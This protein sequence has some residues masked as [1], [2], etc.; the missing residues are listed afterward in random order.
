MNPRN[1]TF[2]LTLALGLLLDQATKL[3]VAANLELSESEIPVVPGWLSIVHAQNTGA[4][5]ST[6]EGALPLFLV[7]TV[8]AVVV[9]LDLVRRQPADL[10]II[11]LSLGMILAGAVG[12]GLDRA[13]MGHVTDFVKVYAG[14]EPLRSWFVESRFGTNVWPIFNVADSLLLVGVAVF[15]LYWLT[16]RDSE[17][18]PD[19]EAPETASP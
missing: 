17:V 11:P 8:I 15:G 13:R 10:R 18:M 16:L 19:D 9:I 4:A 6:M 5:F 12:N 2:T 7:F 1:V 3:W 14:H